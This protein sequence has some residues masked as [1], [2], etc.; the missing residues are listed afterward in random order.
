[1]ISLKRI[2]LLIVLL[3]GIL[4][5]AQVEVFRNNVDTSTYIA[6]EDTITRSPMFEGGDQDFFR[7]IETR[8]NLRT[9]AQSLDFTGET[10]KFSFYVNKDGS[11]SEYTLLSGSNAIVSSEFERIVGSMPKWSPGF[12][13]GKKKRT[14]MVYNLY[15]K[16]VDDFPPVQITLNSNSVEYTDKTKELKIFIMAGTILV[17][18]TLWI[19]SSMK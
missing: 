8:F 9:N 10:I 11:V 12:L 18:A 16:R 1:M 5:S 13:V 14:L 17:A 6:P 19:I 2:G 4:L 15:V 7:F 3:K